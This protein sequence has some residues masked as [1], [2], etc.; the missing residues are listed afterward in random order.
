M[1]RQ[2]KPL[3]PAEIEL[4]SVSEFATGFMANLKAEVTNLA[5]GLALRACVCLQ[6]PTRSIRAV[7]SMFLYAGSTAVMASAALGTM[8][9][10]LPILGVTTFPFWL[11][12]LAIGGAAAAGA[13][14][15]LYYASM[16]RPILPENSNHWMDNIS[17]TLYW[18]KLRPGQLA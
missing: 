18:S 15:G 14:L 16:D 7:V 17:R 5:K 6:S 13:G 9:M 1:A 3:D 11:A 4:P 8:A 10:V 2:V 12:A